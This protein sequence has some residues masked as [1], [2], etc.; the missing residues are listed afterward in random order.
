MARHGPHHVAVKST[1]TCP[2]QIKKKK[3]RERARRSP[4]REAGQTQLGPTHK[5]VVRSQR[6][7]DSNIHMT[8]PG[9]S[10]APLRHSAT[11]ARAAGARGSRPLRSCPY[12]PTISNT[13]I[14]PSPFQGNSHTPTTTDSSPPTQ[15]TSLFPEE[16]R[17][18][19]KSATLWI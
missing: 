17:S 5:K 9:R 2:H 19:R 3:N 1:T 10:R 8:S 7:T 12:L 15:R 11:A 13:T 14:T 18:D 4:E 6:D 16:E